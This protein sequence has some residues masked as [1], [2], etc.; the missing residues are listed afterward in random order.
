M[1]PLKPHCTHI[2]QHL[3]HNRRPHKL[4]LG[5]SAPA[6][7]A[8]PFPRHRICA[9]CFISTK[10]NYL[11]S[12]FLERFELSPAVKSSVI[13]ADWASNPQ[14]VLEVRLPCLLPGRHTSKPAGQCRSGAD[15][16][17]SSHEFHHVWCFNLGL[18]WEC[19]LMQICLNFRRKSRCHC[20]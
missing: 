18:M 4:P 10:R 3:D 13:Y 14:I 5:P 17:Q 19:C 9:R 6:I 11:R 7:C 20:V 16:S 1:V 12:L 2:Y 8:P 15:S